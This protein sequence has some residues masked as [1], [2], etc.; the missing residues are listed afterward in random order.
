MGTVKSLGDGVDMSL[1]IKDFLSKLQ[2]VMGPVIK[3]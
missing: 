3:S 1:H 2:N